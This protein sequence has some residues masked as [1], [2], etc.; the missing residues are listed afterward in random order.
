[1]AL[2][3]P[4]YQIGASLTSVVITGQTVSLSGAL[5]DSGT[6]FTLTAYTDDLDVVVSKRLNE[7]SAVN[8]TIENFVRI[9]NA[10]GFTIRIVRAEA[11]AGV[12]QDPSPFFKEVVAGTFDYWKLVYVVGVAGTPGSQETVTIFGAI[13]NLQDG[14]PDKGRQLSTLSFRQVEVVSGGNLIS[15]DRAVT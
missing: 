5:T 13:E 1:M 7:I 9:I 12:Q 14:Q 15:I 4:L 10:V 3:I 2:N 8:G 11:I 6:A